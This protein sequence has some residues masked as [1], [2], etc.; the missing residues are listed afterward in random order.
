ML[1]PHD[2]QVSQTKIALRSLSMPILLLL[3]AGS[4]AVLLIFTSIKGLF[5]AVLHDSHHPDASSFDLS[6]D[7]EFGGRS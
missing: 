5:G 2:N 3:E 4:W 6:A 7:L 1:R